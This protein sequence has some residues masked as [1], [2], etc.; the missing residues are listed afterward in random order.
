[1][2]DIHLLPDL[3]LTLR[4]EPVLDLDNPKLEFSNSF[5]LTFDTDFFVAKP[6][7]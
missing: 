6:R 7:R 2:K 3:N 1:M 5:Y 4:L